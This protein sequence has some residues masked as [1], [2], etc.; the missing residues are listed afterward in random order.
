MT[1]TRSVA[2][3]M[4]VFQESACF[5][6]RFNQVGQFVAAISR[7]PRTLPQDMRHGILWTSPRRAKHSHFAIRW[8]AH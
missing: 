5:L 4:G 7:H 8:V 3:E 1:E 2:L 6:A